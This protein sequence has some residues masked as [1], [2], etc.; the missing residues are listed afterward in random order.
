MVIDFRSDTVTKPTP[1]MKEAMMKAE[2]GDDVFGEVKIENEELVMNVIDNGPAFPAE[3]SPGYGVKSV[4][5]KMDLLF[6]QA[7]RIY[8]INE[9]VKQVSIHINKLIKNESV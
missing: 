2:V 4:Y 9:P 3:L 7:Y 5:D 8:F 6:P 1:A